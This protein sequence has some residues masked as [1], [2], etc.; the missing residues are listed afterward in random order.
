MVCNRCKT[1]VASELKK[2]RLHPTSIQLGEVSITE[3]LNEESK[4]LL[5]KSLMLL[6]FELIDDRKSR[7]IE[8]IKNTIVEIVHFSNE[9]LRTNLSALISEKLKHDYNYLSNLFSMVEG[10]TIEK[11]FIA[12]KIER[13]KEL[14]KYDELSL[15]E[16][17]DQLNYSSAAYLSSQFKSV[18][19]MTTSQFKS[20]K[21]KNRISLDE[22]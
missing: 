17:A 2:F 12:Q 20:L 9:H 3:E 1:A 4:S 7:M 15:N 16:I 13:V 10:I 11:Y 22:V 5:N 18:T 6:G 14:L 19:G 21:K 8:K